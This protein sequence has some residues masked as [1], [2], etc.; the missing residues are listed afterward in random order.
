MRHKVVGRAGLFLAGVFLMAQLIR[1]DRTNPA[2]DPGAAVDAGGRLPSDVAAVFARSCYDCHSNATRWPWYSAVAP[3]SWGMVRHVTEGRH[4]LNFS[5]W[6]AYPAAQKAKKLDV[7]CDRVRKGEMPLPS[8]LLL[9]RGARLSEADW[10][11]ICDWS[12]DEADRISR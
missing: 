11:L 9:H 8:Y 2:G 4:A 3:M 10:H 12:A 1:P 7:M 6:G 5:T